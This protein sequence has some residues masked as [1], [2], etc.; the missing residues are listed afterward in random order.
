MGEATAMVDSVA[1]RSAIRADQIAIRN[2][3]PIR[4]TNSCWRTTDGSFARNVVGETSLTIRYKWQVVE[5]PRVVVMNN[6][7][8]PFILWIEWMNVEDGQSLISV[9]HFRQ[10]GSLLLAVS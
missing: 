5:L 1:K 9:C 8:A 3:F 4:N 2:S 7:A 6:L 10:K